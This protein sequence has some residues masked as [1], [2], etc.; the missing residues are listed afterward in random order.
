MKIKKKKMKCAI[1]KQ[2]MCHLI[3]QTAL[4]SN[5]NKYDSCFPSK[6]EICSMNKMSLMAP[7][8]IIWTG[9]SNFKD[10]FPPHCIL[11][12]GLSLEEVHS[13]ISIQPDMMYRPN[14]KK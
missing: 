6:K 10:L 13:S 5:S 2:N 3:L 8:H 1:P 14:I 9:E 7:E 12:G 11:F 4:E